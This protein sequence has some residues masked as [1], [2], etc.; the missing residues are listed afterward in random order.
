MGKGR[1]GD[2][3][4]K[5]LLKWNVVEKRIRELVNADKYLTPKGKEA[6]AQYKKEQAE[7]AMRRE[8]EKLEH[9]I[10]VECKD[11]IEK[12]IAEKFDGYTFRGY[13]RGRYPAVWEG[14]CRDCPC[15]Y[16]HALIP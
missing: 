16:N 2:P 11:A 5:V 9:G 1:I 13:R 10:R 4:A 14:T 15:Q 8:Q 7:E 6:F 3:Y 12:A